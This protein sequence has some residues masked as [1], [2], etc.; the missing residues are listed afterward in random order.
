MSE[1]LFLAHRIPFPPDRGD[2]IRSHN[3]LKRLAALAPV[4]VATFVESEDD[5]AHEGDLAR[6]SASHCIVS[7]TRPVPL[8]TIEAVATGIPVSLA[9][10]ASRRIRDFVAH[11]L[12]SRPVSVIVVFSG[13][14]AQYLPD[15]FDG[16]IVMDLVDVDSA[17]FEDYAKRAHAPVATLYRREARLLSRFEDRV[18]ARADRTILSTHEEAALF[19]SRLT[20][21]DGNRVSAMSNGIDTRFFDPATVRAVPDAL[22]G[23]ANIVFT[24]QMDYPPNIEAVTMFARDAMP[25]VRQ[26]IGNA[27]F[28]IVGRAP[29]A[30]VRALEGCNG[31]RVHGGVPD[32]RP[33]LAGADLVVAPLLIARGVQNKVLEAMAM[34][35]PVLA[36]PEAA[37]GIGAKEGDQIAIADGVEG[38]ARRTVEM[39]ENPDAASRMGR[40]GRAFVEAEKAWD[41]VLA[42]LAAWCGLDQPDH[43]H[44]A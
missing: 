39:L 28:H 12:A 42:P 2:K 17:K 30:K 33:W 11:V 10:F 40:A 37:L 14:M 31:T 41:A 25:L 35:R 20:T 7:R 32:M 38:L 43:R 22:G 19:R 27:R 26:R 15:R 44:A 8:A 9:A 13:Q 4:H 34:A 1:I 6:L 5:A 29:T 18:A 24:G 21:A 16:R 36:T 23:G 3:I